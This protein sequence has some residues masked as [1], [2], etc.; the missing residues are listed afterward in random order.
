MKAPAANDR[1]RKFPI[2]ISVLIIILLIGLGLYVGPNLFDSTPPSLTITGLEQDKR[3]R[4]ALTL[5]ITAM[6]EKS[7]LGSL[8]VQIDDA[9]PNPLSLVEAEITLWTLQTAAFPDGRH[10][11]SVTATDRSLRKKPDAVHASVLH[12]QH[13]ATVSYSPGNAP[14]WTRQNTC[15][16]SS[17]GRVALRD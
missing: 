11:V 9:P 6:D 10:T 17:G 5:N 1:T 2:L 16:L 4:G 15:T 12:R 8:T 3:Y 13:P 14:R 7:G